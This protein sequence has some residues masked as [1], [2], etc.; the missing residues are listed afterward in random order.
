MVGERRDA[1][2]MVEWLVIVDRSQSTGPRAERAGTVADHG[3]LAQGRAAGQARD[4][5][6]ARRDVGQDD[7]IAGRDVG[8]IGADRLHDSRMPRARG[9]SASAGSREPSMTDRSE[10]HRPGGDDPDQDLT[11]P[12]LR[13][14]DLADLERPRLRVRPGDT[15]L[16]Q[17]GAV[18][19]SSLR[20]VSR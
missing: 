1:E 11:R 2:V 12:R 5:A 13:Q 14:L 6:A 19:S 4:A 20:S 15:R 8:D 10:W 17:D 18:E 3:R 7:V 16:R 9:A